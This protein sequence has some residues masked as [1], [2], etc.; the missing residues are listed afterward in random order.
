SL[1]L[2]IAI[3]WVSTRS[4]FARDVLPLTRA[5]ATHPEADVASG[6]RAVVIDGERH[7]FGTMD[8]FAK[9]SHTFRVRNEG[10]APLEL[11]LG[12]TTCKCTV[13]NLTTS[14]LAPGEGTDV[15][16]DWQVKTGDEMFEQ[17]AEL[18]TNDPHHNPIRLVIYGKARDTL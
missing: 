18:I 14:R 4:E 5:E 13:G 7:D 8:R 2:G 10:P 6:P 15:K 17:S 16:L 12:H 9:G 1:V 3:G 11:A